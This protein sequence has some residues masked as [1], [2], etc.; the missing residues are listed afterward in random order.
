MLYIKTVPFWL[1]YN[2]LA[3]VRKT[4]QNWLRVVTVVFRTAW[5]IRFFYVF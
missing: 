1:K 4:I 3:I 2:D 5:H